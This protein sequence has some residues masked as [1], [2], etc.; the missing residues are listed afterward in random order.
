[1]KTGNDPREKKKKKS[2]CLEK[3]WVMERRMLGAGL[4]KT[5]ARN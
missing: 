5:E 2:V 3:K 1:M 4:L